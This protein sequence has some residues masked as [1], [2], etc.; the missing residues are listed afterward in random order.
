M[1]TWLKRELRMFTAV[2]IPVRVFRIMNKKSLLKTALV[3]ATILS[4]AGLFANSAS[5]IQSGKVDPNNLSEASLEGK[6][7]SVT[8][9]GQKLDVTF[10]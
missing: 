5:Q 7:F 2:L 9:G 6:S 10:R 8:Y 4:G 3:S 1:L